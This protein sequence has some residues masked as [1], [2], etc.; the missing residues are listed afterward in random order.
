MDFTRECVLKLVPAPGSSGD[1]RSAEELA[2][3]ARVCARLNHP[4]IVRMHDFFE[5]GENLVL[6][7]EHFA[8][9][10]LARLWSHLRRRKQ[11]LG[12][13]AIWFIAHELFSALQ[14]AHSLA[15]EQGAPTPVIHRDVQ[16][17]HIVMAADAQVRLAGFGIAK[18]SG[19]ESNTAVGFVKGTPAYMAPE[20]ARGEKVSLRVDVFAAGLVVWE[21]LTGR[22]VVPG[23]EVGQGAELLALIGGRRVEPLSS[24]RH[25]LPRELVAAVDACLEFSPTKRQIRCGDVVR[26]IDK[27]VD[28]N[29]GRTDLK[30]RLVQVR[31]AA[32]R[33]PPASSAASTRTSIPPPASTAPRA[34]ASRYPGIA[35]RMTGRAGEGSEGEAPAPRSTRRVPPVMAPPSSRP[36]ASEQLLESD[37]EPPQAPVPAAG[38]PRSVPAKGTLLGLAPMA[39]QPAAPL[40][41]PSLP[42]MP[43]PPL[44]EP[45]AHLR[46][47]P[48]VRVDTA[49]TATQRAPAAVVISHVEPGERVSTGD[50]TVLTRRSVFLGNGSRVWMIGGVFGAIVATAILTAGLVVH[51]TS[52]QPVVPGASATQSAATSPARSA[53]GGA[54]TS[55]AP[56]PASTP[57]TP[58]ATS[59]ARPVATASAVPPPADTRPILRGLG[60]LIVRSPPEGTVYVSGVPLGETNERLDL[61]CGR[62][63]FVR[64]G[65]RPGPRGL[66]DTTW[67]SPGQSVLIRCGELVEVAATPRY[68]VP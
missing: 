57:T 54:T 65:T 17:A 21:M 39:P 23:P 14:H 53:A 60:A 66:V 37:V 43:P 8:G 44:A 18:I 13:D 61:G 64:V 15:D 16:P 59:E 32:L 24:V 6:V 45:A 3:E 58:P 7:F 56:P 67:L 50:T 10:S 29:A 2:Q 42:A 11:Q 31:N 51:F 19:A 40:T 36:P 4:A 62:Q 46:P 28:L 41:P 63:K 38:R 26:W 1:P 47:P 12:D 25:D 20:Q 48:G 55:A 9:V 27:L 35:T 22:S 5:H 34:P 68:S 33:A 30:E 52:R 49:P